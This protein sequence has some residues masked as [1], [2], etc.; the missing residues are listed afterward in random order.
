MKSPAVIPRNIPKVWNSGKEKS[1]VSPV[2]P[3]DFMESM[4]FEVS[5]QPVPTNNQN[6]DRAI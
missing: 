2:M 6:K 4:T 1:S 3:T 5:E